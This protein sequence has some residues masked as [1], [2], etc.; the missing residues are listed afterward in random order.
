MA[1]IKFPPIAEILRKRF[2]SPVDPTLS[3]AIVPVVVLELDRPEWRYLEAVPICCGT[4]ATTI[5]NSANVISHMLSNPAGSRLLVTLEACWGILQY[6]PISAGNSPGAPRLVIANAGLGDLS[7]Q[8]NMRDFR[9]NIGGSR[10]STAQLRSDDQAASLGTVL[11]RT[12]LMM[13]ATQGTTVAKAG[14]DVDLPRSFVIP[15][16]N[17]IAIEGTG[18]AGSG[19]DSTM[20]TSFF[21]TERPMS[22]WELQASNLG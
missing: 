3:D 5:N 17:A 21:W 12:R 18:L 9:W 13:A 16:G 14:W 20:Q 6:D 7:L 4:L 11:A 8:P 22:S 1:D 19:I 2:Q 10:N 15:P